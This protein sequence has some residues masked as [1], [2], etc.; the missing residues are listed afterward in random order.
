MLLI[1]WCIGCSNKHDEKTDLVQIKA[2]L[3][4]IAKTKIDHKD[5]HNLHRECKNQVDIKKILKNSKNQSKIPEFREF[6]L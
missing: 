3:F 6:D 1:L 2:G 4:I 5:V